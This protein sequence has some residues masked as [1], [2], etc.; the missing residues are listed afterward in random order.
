[1]TSPRL[2]SKSVK[3]KFVKGRKFLTK[4]KKPSPAICGLCGGNLF[5]VPRKGKYEMS[6]LSKIKRRP[7][8]I[9]GGV[10]CASCTQRLLI[11][12]TRLEKGVLKK[13]DIPVSHLKFLNSLI[14]LK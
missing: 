12:K 5:G 14:E 8:R 11:E 10:L 2:R 9:F 13:E 3:K 6:K 4:Q 7:S 1:M